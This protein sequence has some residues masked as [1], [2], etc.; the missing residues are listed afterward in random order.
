M[1]VHAHE[2]TPVP[3]TADHPGILSL[4]AAG[5]EETVPAGIPYGALPLPSLNRPDVREW[6]AENAE[7]AIFVMAGTS[8]EMKGVPAISVPATAEDYELVISSM[9]L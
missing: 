1:D 3:T 6:L 4:I 5:S 7:C 2:H 9:P 8:L